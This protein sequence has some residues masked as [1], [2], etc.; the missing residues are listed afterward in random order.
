[1]V[2]ALPAHAS[3][4]AEQIVFA[5]GDLSGE[6]FRVAPDG[7]G[8]TRVVQRD[9]S[10][11]A[12]A[13][14]PDGQSIAFSGFAPGTAQSGL[15]LMGSDGS[16]PKVVRGGCT[17]GCWR[18]FA[19]DWSPNGRRLVV[20]VRGHIQILRADGSVVRKLT[21]GRRANS[22]PAWSP[23]GRRIVFVRTGPF[24]NREVLYRIRANGTN[25]RRLGRGAEPDWSPDGKTIVFTDYDRSFPELFLMSAD[26]SDRR[27]LTRTRFGAWSPAWAPRGRTI[28]FARSFLREDSVSLIR[29][30]GSNERRLFRGAFGPAWSPDGTQLLVGRARVAILDEQMAAIIKIERDGTL[31]EWLLTPESDRDVAVS[32]DGARTA[33][34][35]VRPFS[36]NGVYVADADGS[37]ESFLHSGSAPDW[38]PDGSQVLLLDSDGMYVVDADGTDPLKLPTPV[39]ANGRPLS[40][41]EPAWHPGGAH[42][43]F[44]ARTSSSN[45]G[46]VWQMELT[47]PLATRLTGADCYP[48]V[49]EFD[50][51]DGSTLVYSAWGCGACARHLFSV[52]LPGGVPVELTT[53]PRR[54]DGEPAVSPAGDRIAFLRRAGRFSFGLDPSSIWV[55]DVDGDNE[56]QVTTGLHDWSPAWLPAPAP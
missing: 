50:W 15:W 47:A 51:I 56:T 30:N 6:L 24:G 37:N 11:V 17:Q 28:A 14:S 35:S 44:V 4:Q 29:A 25:L 36:Q 26:G 16:D 13:W 21:E 19:A 3:A 38:S 32:P 9:P 49:T 43:S 12:P 27:R 10:G 8:E 48:R 23:N 41:L 40:P 54:S 53:E 22:D 55:M 1:V 5:R 45:C 31:L 52:P 20:S 42:V 46:D 2:G 33:F 34:T 7:T 18:L 39:R